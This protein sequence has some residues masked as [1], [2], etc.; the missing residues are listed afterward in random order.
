[1]TA[2]PSPALNVTLPQPAGRRF[3]L[4]LGGGGARGLAHIPMLE[5]LDELGVRPDII[6]GTS[7]GALIGAGYAAGMSGADLREYVLELFG[8]R[9]AALSL[10]R[11]RWTGRVWDYWNPLT[12]ALI[13]GVSLIE[14]ALPALLPKTFEELR[15]PLL[16]VATD[17]CAQNECVLS[18]G[19]LIPAIAA[20]AAIPALFKTVEIG[21]RILLD[22]GFV[23][24]TPFD[25]LRGRADV[26]AAV[27]VMG[28]VPPLT[29][30]PNSVDA[31]MASTQI[32]L[33]SIVVEKLRW[34]APDVFVQPD[35]GRFRVLDFWKA[36]EI[37]EATAPAKEE[38]KRALCNLVK[39]N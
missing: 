18:Q 28:G 12:P 10:M 22:G 13:N 1:M 7:I 8:R 30:A 14:T 4:A 32:A 6:A 26:V 33:R 17:Y 2:D 15:I 5:A 19:A 16:V 25:L 23:N 21:G 20:S 31:V 9:F 3:G 34:A 38:F 35:V 39:P 24:P 27:D 11:Q 37:W 36:A 29:A